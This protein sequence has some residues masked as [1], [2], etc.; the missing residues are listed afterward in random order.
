M[1]LTAVT[2]AALREYLQRRGFLSAGEREFAIT[3]AER[4]SGS[5]DVSIEHDRHFTQATRNE[6]KR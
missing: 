3:P 1:P 5:A 6:P 4:G 2:Q